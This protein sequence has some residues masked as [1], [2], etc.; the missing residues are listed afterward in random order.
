MCGVFRRSRSRALLLGPLLICFA[1]ALPCPKLTTC[2]WS[3]LTAI[4]YKL[5]SFY[6]KN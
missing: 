6:Y 3:S 5:A 4:L 1:A 2:Y